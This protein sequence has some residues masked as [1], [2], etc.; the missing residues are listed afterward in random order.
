M[1]QDP[2]FDDLRAKKQI[3]VRRMI[4]TV[5]G[6]RMR[7][8]GSSG[9][10]GNAYDDGLRIICGVGYNSAGYDLPYDQSKSG[11][12]LF[13]LLQYINHENHF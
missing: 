9:P 3:V 4:H 5:Y 11:K 6:F 2:E 12:F 8:M 13:I 7:T 10:T 1:A